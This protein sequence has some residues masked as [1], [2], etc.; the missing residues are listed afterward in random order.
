M[1]LEKGEIDAQMEYYQPVSGVYA[2]DLIKAS[3]VE[4]CIVPDVGVP[5]ILIFGFKN[6]PSNVTEFRQA[7]SYAIDYEEVI[8]MIVAG[9]GEVPGKGFNSPALPG[10]DADLPELEYDPDKANE[11]LDASGFIDKDGDGLREMPDGSKLQ[12]PLTPS[13]NPKFI[14]TAEVISRQLRDV[15]LDVNVQSLSSDEFRRVFYTDKDFTMIITQSSPFTNLGADSAA[16]IF[17]DLPGMYGT[18]K[19]PEIIE[20]VENA[21]HSK[22]VDELTN[23]RKLIQAYIAR[24]Q[25]MIALV[26]G[27]A[28]YP[29][30]TDRWEG[31]TPMYG[32]GPATYW[33]W[34]SLEPISD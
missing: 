2:A 12:I 26:W 5:V 29:V 1:A 33:S 9:Y 23:N 24:E 4:L 17:V 15:G 25:P 32:Y 30:G 20:L 13:P 8:D 11:L 31:W 27:D 7:I 14:R 21:I 22:D 19:D 34:F 16:S 18:C 6:Y 10:Y 28:I 3:G